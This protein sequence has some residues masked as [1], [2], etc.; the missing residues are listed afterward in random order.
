MNRASYLHRFRIKKTDWVIKEKRRK[1]GMDFSVPLLR[2]LLL[3]FFFFFELK[4]SPQE[5]LPLQP[6][7]VRVKQ[8]EDFWNL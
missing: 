6:A 4:M 3:F 2:K 7:A 8:G 5:T 1:R